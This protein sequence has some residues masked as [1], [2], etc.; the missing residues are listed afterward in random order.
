M[1]SLRGDFE[2]SAEAIQQR[3]GGSYYCSK[4]LRGGQLSRMSFLL[5]QLEEVGE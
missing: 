3:R 4:R 5:E 2:G 1:R